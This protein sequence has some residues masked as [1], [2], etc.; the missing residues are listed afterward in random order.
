[1]IIGISGKARSG[2]GEFANIAVAEFGA[3]QVS[4]AGPLKKE[5]GEFLT[6]CKVEWEPRHLY[7]EQKDREQL[8]RVRLRNIPKSDLGEHFK[9][10]VMKHGHRLATSPERKSFYYAFTP[11]LLMQHWGTEIR[12]QHYGD[13]YWI[14]QAMAQCSDP[15]TLY[16]IDDVRY[17]NEAQA[18]LDA[19]GLLYR[20]SRSGAPRTSSPHHLSEIALD[21]WQDWSAILFN[22]GTLWQY[23]EQIR[24]TLKVD[25]QL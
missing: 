19:G 4:F 22:T 12:R 2:K 13:D 10:F 25:L 1:M 8:L 20:V 24:G 16:V 18:I 11:R 3:V 14:R 15:N 5:V 21:K 9:S 7:G 6:A 17:P 23:H